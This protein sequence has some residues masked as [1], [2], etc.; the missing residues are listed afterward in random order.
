MASKDHVDDTGPRGKQG[1]RGTDMSQPIDRVKR[2]IYKINTVSAE[3][4]SY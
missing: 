2:Y 1:H 4:L 3:N